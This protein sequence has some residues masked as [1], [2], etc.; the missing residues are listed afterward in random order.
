MSPD[1]RAPEIAD[2]ASRVS[3]LPAVRRAMVRQ[4]QRLGASA[5]VVMEGRDIGTV[6]F[7]EAR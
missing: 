3:A 1:I 2:A 7:P 4:Q 5:S 6:V